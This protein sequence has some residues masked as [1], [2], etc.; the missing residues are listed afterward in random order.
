MLK[1]LVL[2]KYKYFSYIFMFMYLAMKKIEKRNK[3]FCRAKKV[4]SNEP[5]GR[6]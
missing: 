6:L 2:V 1:I 5:N 4:A 3:P